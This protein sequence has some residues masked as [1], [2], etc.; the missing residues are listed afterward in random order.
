MDAKG[1]TP[2]ALS[3]LAATSCRRIDLSGLRPRAP[4]GPIS[5]CQIASS[6]G[7]STFVQL[8]TPQPARSLEAAEECSVNYC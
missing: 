1:G 2:L 3:S 4:L 7:G 5:L 8:P 6:P